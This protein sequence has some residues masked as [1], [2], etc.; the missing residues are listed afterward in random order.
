MDDFKEQRYFIKKGNPISHAYIKHQ[1][2]LLCSLNLKFSWKLPRPWCKSYRL[3]APVEMSIV[4]VPDK[5]N[6]KLYVDKKGYEPTKHLFMES[7]RMKK[8]LRQIINEVF[9]IP[10]NEK[11]K[12]QEQFEEL[13]KT[14]LEKN[15]PI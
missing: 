9:F 6:G 5:D 4:L 11:E 1:A 14:A 12:E 13:N 3:S 7:V 10:L 2:K 8:K 15:W